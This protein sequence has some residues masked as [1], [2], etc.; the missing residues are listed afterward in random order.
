MAMNRAGEKKAETVAL[1][2]RIMQRYVYYYLKFSNKKLC[3]NDF[4]YAETY[5]QQNDQLGNTRRNVVPW[6]GLLSTSTLP[7]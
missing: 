5:L 3:C 1:L 2:K 4:A 7:L 6:P